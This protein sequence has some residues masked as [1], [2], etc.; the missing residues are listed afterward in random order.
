MNAG[1]PV[2]WIFML[3]MVL[4]VFGALA[5]IMW[6]SWIAGGIVL[7]LVVLVPGLYMVRSSPVGAP[8]MVLIHESATP[9]LES[10]EPS[11]EQVQTADVFPSLDDAAVYLARRLCGLVCDGVLSKKPVNQIQ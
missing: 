2:A 10:Q 8:G 11:A 4:I 1:F 3:L 5:A 6:R 7:L 9:A